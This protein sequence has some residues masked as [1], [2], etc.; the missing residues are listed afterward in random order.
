MLPYERQLDSLVPDL[1]H[2]Q[3][4]A[5]LMKDELDKTHVAI[6]NSWLSDGEDVSSSQNIAKIL[7][8]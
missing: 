8:R 2:R 5:R 4:G 1:N 6:L 7:Q 3:G